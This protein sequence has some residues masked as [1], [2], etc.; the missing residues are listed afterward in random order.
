MKTWLSIGK[1]EF[2]VNIYFIAF[3]SL[4]RRKTKTFFL[5]VGLFLSVASVVALITISEN[6]NKSIAT[7]L[8]EFGANII[9]TPK[10]DQLMISYGGLSLG[11][12]SFNNSQLSEN[13]LQKINTIKNR[14]NLSIIAPKLFETVNLNR[15]NI[16]IAGVRFPDELKLKK[17]WV[18][19]G[20]SPV[21]MNNILVGSNTA[22]ALHIKLNDTLTINEQRFVISGILSNTGSQDDN[23]IFID[24][25]TAQNLFHKPSKLSL[26]EMAALCYD[27]P[28]EDI[29]S[30]TSSVLPA[31][32]VTPIK[33]NIESKMMAVNSFERFSLGIS[34]VIL[35]TSFLII[36]TNVNA[37]VTERTKEIGIF[38]SVGYRKSHILKIIL[39]EVITASLTAGLLGFFVGI[40]SAKLILPFLSMHALTSFTYNFT[41]LPIA[42][43]LSLFIGITACI[44]PAIKAS[45]LDP[46]VAFRYI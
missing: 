13:D 23:L 41:T 33:Q 10:S 36:F 20:K 31:A 45:R 7:N 35:V 38:K 37:S 32:N 1:E 21:S 27:C 39:T 16:L 28:I 19:K 26:I 5:I 3:Q 25:L 8:D 30:Q 6:I 46:T 44:Y 4:R 14:K 29:V 17:W 2:N 22:E 43:F 18:I 15:K 12:V 24:I 42:I 9:I 34:L 11:E 40:F